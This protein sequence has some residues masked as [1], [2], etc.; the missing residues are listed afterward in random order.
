MMCRF[1]GS[2]KWLVPL[3]LLV[4]WY[5]TELSG[6][7]GVYKGEHCSRHALDHYKKNLLKNPRRHHIILT[8]LFYQI[9]FFLATCSSPRDFI[10]IFSRSSDFFRSPKYVPPSTPHHHQRSSSSCSLFSSYIFFYY[11][12]WDMMIRSAV[13]CI[14]AGSA[15][16]SEAVGPNKRV[17]IGLSRSPSAQLRWPTVP[18]IWLRYAAADRLLTTI[19]V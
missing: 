2:G 7:E 14:F 18:H 6:T 11:P 19:A 5:S 12:W 9:E 17:A 4:H 16:I 10:A 1:D 8:I 3:S 15:G 13:S